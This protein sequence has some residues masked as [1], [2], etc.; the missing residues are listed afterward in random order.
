M[1]TLPLTFH[2]TPPTPSR[3]L[4]AGAASAPLGSRYILF[5]DDD[6]QLHPGR[7]GSFRRLKCE[8]PRM[9]C[10]AGN[11]GYVEIDWLTFSAKCPLAASRTWW[12]CWRG[13]GLSSWQQVP[14]IALLLLYMPDSHYQP[15][16]VH[17]IRL[18]II[19][20]SMSIC[21]NISASPP[22]MTR[23]TIIPGP[24]PR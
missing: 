12:G 9:K 1:H 3:S 10:I 8:L 11:K 24:P 2:T 18:Y 22:V 17:R 4:C 20:I 16:L 14:G 13:T 6:V 5:L 7:C 19:S 23:M 21:P 15:S